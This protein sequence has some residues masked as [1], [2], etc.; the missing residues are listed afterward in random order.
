MNITPNKRKRET[1][2]GAAAGSTALDKEN[3]AYN[4]G[5]MEIKSLA[6]IRSEPF[7]PAN[8]FEVVRKPP[9][10]KKKIEIGSEGNCFVNPAL[11]LDGPEHVIN[12]FEIRRAVFATSD[13]SAVDAHCFVNTG[14][15]IR[16]PEKEVR[17]PFEI[18]RPSLDNE[19]IYIN[20]LQ[21]I[22]NTNILKN[23][24]GFQD[25]RTRA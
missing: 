17:N 7:Y 1:L 10:K 4:H 3:F 21:L 16:G 19:G 23:L 6:D 18:M 9:K 25:W 24:V 20:C 13:R 5:L 2:G 22:V 8:P 12:P 15:N 11:N 14:L